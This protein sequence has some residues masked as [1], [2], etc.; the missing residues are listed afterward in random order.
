MGKQQEQITR[1]RQM[2]RRLNTAL[3][4]VKRLTPALDKWDGTGGHRD[5]R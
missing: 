5:P 3:A 2:E 4:A 1:I